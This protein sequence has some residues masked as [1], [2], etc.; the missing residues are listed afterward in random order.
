[1]NQAAEKQSKKQEADNQAENQD[2]GGRDIKEKA[3]KFQSVEMADKP[4]EPEAPA[5]PIQ[6]NQEEQEKPFGCTVSVSWQRL[7]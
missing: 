4:K 6:E 1:M 7:V 5:A 3:P 2:G